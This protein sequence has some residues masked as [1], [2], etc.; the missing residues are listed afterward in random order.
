MA[1]DIRIGRTLGPYDIEELLGG[2]GMATVYRGVHRSLGV[3]RAIKVMSS[4]LAANDSFVE[5]FYREAR[6]A[7]GLRHP[8]IVQMFD[9]ARHDGQHYL[10][11]ELL[12]GR[13]LH[14]VIQQDAPLPLARVA[15]FVGQLADALDYAH[16]Q[17]IAHRDV[18]P[19]NAFVGP[20]DRLTLVDFGIAR[21]ADATHLT[22]THGI[23]TP[24]YMAPEVFEEQLAEPGADHHQ[25]AVGNDLYS[26]GVVAYV[27]V[28]GKVPFF[29]RTP[30]AV[31]YAQVNHRPPAPRSIRPDLP[32]AVEEIILRQL[33]K[34]PGERY[35]VA[36]AFADAFA[37][38]VR[39][40][41][42]GGAPPTRCSPAAVVPNGSAHDGQAW[43][44]GPPRRP[45]GRVVDP[46]TLP[47][48]ATARPVRSGRGWTALVVALSLLAVGLI[49]YATARETAILS[50]V[51][52]MSG[53][54]EA[55]RASNTLSAAAPTNAPTTAPTSPPL[56]T[57]TS[58]PPTVAPTAVPTVATPEIAA[59]HT[60][61]G[62]SVEQQ[63]DEALAQAVALI[64]DQ[65]DPNADVALETLDRL[66]RELDPVSARRPIVEEV[67]I[68]MLLD[69]SQERIK[70]AFTLKNAN[71]G[72]E[73][74]QI[75]A[76]T[77]RRFD[78]AAELRPHDATLQERVNRSREQL[79]LT[80]LWVDFDAAYYARQN[81]AQIAALT[82]IMEKS[83]EFR[84]PEGAA[85]EKLFAAW[86]AK[87]EEAWAAR[88]TDLARASLDEAAKVDP[89]HPRPRDLRAAWFRQ[90]AAPPARAVAPA[91]AVNR[92]A[93]VQ[94]GPAEAPAPAPEA[95]PAPPQRTQLIPHNSYTLE[96]NAPNV[97]NQSHNSP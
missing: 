41:S 53:I 92:A 84:T 79:D 52:D 97:S 74:Q 6:L 28:T 95:Q 62:P 60:P 71:E 85:K 32:P 26:L 68:R 73:S 88:Q 15:H 67:M 66:H 90:R 42:P 36:G 19:A 65:K 48:S 11:M 18:K 78:R 5:L 10:V 49:G 27:L 47:A 33:A 22:V 69:D 31:A 58:V 86:I 72:R 24:E 21:A 61:S 23:G 64:Q 3:Q 38:A 91:R 4:S 50:L 57:A 2:G 94:S 40:A 1:G 30:N 16:R 96:I 25:I 55:R 39:Q 9:I 12:K 54:G 35:P 45:A 44:S 14:E 8:N 81:D 76:T 34:K 7:A 70:A 51:A 83:P 59:A 82:R 46:V 89:L 77:R 75:I 17:D 37:E 80:S 56:P 63:V 20:N 29:G 13:S 87:A 93:P 43:Q